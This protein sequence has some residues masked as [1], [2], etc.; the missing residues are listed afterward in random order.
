MLSRKL[1]NENQNNSN[2]CDNESN[3]SE[4]QQ[5]EQ[6]FL[7][8]VIENQQNCWKCLMKVMSWRTKGFQKE[9]KKLFY[10]GFAVQ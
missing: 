3:N 5:K 9:T 10:C 2:N 6:L 4:L 7:Q 1:L 8:Q